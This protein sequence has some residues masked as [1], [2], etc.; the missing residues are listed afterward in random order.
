MCNLRDWDGG[1]MSPRQT[2]TP[3]HALRL[4]LGIH[5]AYSFGG[6]TPLHSVNLSVM[7]DG[8]FKAQLSSPTREREDRKL[9][10]KNA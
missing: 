9:R 7:F 3:A 1:L 10:P 2:R 6:D 4:T 8:F 5:T